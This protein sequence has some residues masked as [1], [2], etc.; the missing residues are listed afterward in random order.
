VRHV[1]AFVELVEKDLPGLLVD[2]LLGNPG[3]LAS[4]V[5][6]CPLLGEEEA[7]IEQGVTEP[8]SITEE[9]TDL[10]VIDLAKSATILTLDAA[11]VSA[12]LGEAGTIADENAVG[13]IPDFTDMQTKFAEDGG[14]APGGDAEEVLKDFAS[15]ANLVS[16]WLC[17]FARQRREFPLEEL[18]RVT[19]L[20]G[21]LEQWQIPLQE[22]LDVA[23]KF[24]HLLCG[25]DGIVE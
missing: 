6:L 5:I 4:F 20:L 15:D 16:N 22:R 23:G 18:L 3:L 7:V 25:Q 8:T 1:L 12:F 21:A 14:I 17:G 13:V 10:T 2:N 11:G 24:S 9:D 19:A